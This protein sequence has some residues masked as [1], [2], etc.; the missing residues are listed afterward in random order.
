M[1]EQSAMI[2]DASL[3]DAVVPIVPGLPERLREGIDA[4]DVGCG[5]GHAVN[6]LAAAFPASRFT[7]LDISTEGIAAGRA[8]ADERGLTNATFE[9]ADV[10]ALAGPP[11]FDLVTAFDAIHDQAAPDAVLRG[12]ADVLRDDGTF[13]MVDIRASSHLH[14]NIGHPLGPYVYG[15]ST[16][17]CMTVSLA[18]GGAGLGTAWGEELAQE[19]LAAAGF[20]DVQVH[21]LDSDVANTYYVCRKAV[22][23]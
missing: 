15:M 20:G 13:L 4:A 23:G 2:F 6:V 9:V 22:T 5:Q 14:E 12:I 17:H 19:M 7:G 8:E 1:A 18:A 16:M 21:H 3:V 10:A 11:R